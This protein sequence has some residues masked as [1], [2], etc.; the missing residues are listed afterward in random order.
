[1]KSDIKKLEKS[2]IEITIEL[3]ELELTP[4][5]TKAAEK[6]STENKIEGFRPGKAPY[7]IIK[8]RFGEGAI[9]NEAVDDIISKSYYEVL[10]A[11]EIMTIGAP[12][13]KVE[14]MAPGNPFVF[15]AKVAVLPKVKLGDY[16]TIKL[17]KK[18]VEV[19]EDQVEKVIGEITKLRATEKLVE[20]EAR[21]GDRLE[22]DFDVFLDKVPVDN[23][24]QTKYPI[25]IGEGRFIPGFEEQITGMKAGEVKEFELKFPEKYYEKNLAGKNCDCKV[26]C[27]GVYEVEMPKLDDEFAKMVSGG[28]F[29]TVKEMRDGIR[30]NLE[31]EERIKKDQILEI[32][33]LD[34]IVEI[35]EFEELPEVL[36]HSEKHR[37]LHELEDSVESQGF[38][39]EDYLSSIK[40]T[41]EELEDEFTPQAE[42][43]VKTSIIAREIYQ[44]QKI[45][46]S[47]DEVGLEIEKL[48]TAYQNNPEAQKQLESETYKDYLRNMIGNKKVIEY[49]KGIIVGE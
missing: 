7:E 26:T 25:T 2:E 30:E 41:T 40:K 24:K 3:S 39:F 9:L 34:K 42:K 28:K 37:M 44:E 5:L 48:L 19:K 13:I 23:G 22:I 11:N 16:K 35:S 31:E 45:E 18:K 8:Q 4:Y 27:K 33:M 38:K 12:D 15:K 14:K 47:D 20:R 17:E 46:V 43:R 1:M 21:Q 49:L 32:E 29:S 10:K 6:I 36:L